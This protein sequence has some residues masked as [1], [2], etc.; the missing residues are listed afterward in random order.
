MLAIYFCNFC[1]HNKKKTLHVGS[2]INFMFEWQK[3]YFTR[4]LCCFCHSNIKFT[5]FCHPLCATQQKLLRQEYSMQ[6]YAQSLLVQPCFAT[7]YDKKS[8][9]FC[10]KIRGTNGCKTAS[11]VYEWRATKPRETLSL[12]HGF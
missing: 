5:S 4:L 12:S 3:Q 10:S 1:L 11:S 6:R 8:V 2:D 7:K 9:S